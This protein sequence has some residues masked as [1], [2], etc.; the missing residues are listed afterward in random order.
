M[1]D[2]ANYVVIQRVLEVAPLLRTDAKT[3][4]STDFVFID[5]TQQKHSEFSFFSESSTSELSLETQM[6]FRLLTG[7]ELTE[8]IKDRC[9]YLNLH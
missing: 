2:H 4:F 7:N 6:R 5:E 9:Q 8:L 1:R 3:P